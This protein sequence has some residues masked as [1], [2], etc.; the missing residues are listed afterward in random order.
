MKICVASDSGASS[1]VQSERASDLQ[2]FG[3]KQDGELVAPNFGPFGCFLPSSEGSRATP[4]RP[5]TSRRVASS[6]GRA[7]KKAGTKTTRDRNF[8]SACQVDRKPASKRTSAK[9]G[10]LVA[11]SR[12]RRDKFVASALWRREFAALVLLRQRRDRSSQ[13]GRERRA[14][15]RVEVTLARELLM[16]HDD[17]LP[18]RTTEEAKNSNESTDKKRLRTQLS[19]S[20]SANLHGVALEALAKWRHCVAASQ[21]SSGFIVHQSDTTTRDTTMR[22]SAKRIDS[23]PQSSG[24]E[25]GVR[26]REWPAAA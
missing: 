22:E 2:I 8:I 15:G 25:G 6:R 20:S 12:K 1:R 17:W 4:T 10:P 23:R 11:P 18:R 26:S 16:R 14:R 13:R 9:T 24:P 21:P 3:R 5:P 7:R 19:L